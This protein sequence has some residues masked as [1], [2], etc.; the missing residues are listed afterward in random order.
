MARPGLDKSE[1]KKAC[2]ALA[3]QGRYASVDAVRAELGNTGSKTTI[4][5]YLKELEL[6][7]GQVNVRQVK[8]A[9]TIQE[10][11]DALA[12]RLHADADA[13][14]AQAAAEHAARLQANALEMDAM[15]GQIQAL[16]SQV[17]AVE[18][19]ARNLAWSHEQQLQAAR[20]GAA[21]PAGFGLF[22]ASLG[23][24]RN[25]KQGWSR[26][27]IFNCRSVAEVEATPGR[28]IDAGFVSSWFKSPV[29]SQQ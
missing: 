27:N 10:V 23:S 24:S 15:R 21:R 17:Q 12:A 8:T 26:L 9:Q 11:V 16:Q 2:E 19:I 3:A 5:K 1:V 14:V 20:Q 25:G 7:A 28:D 18:A 4:H 6:E 22:G 13:R 29:F